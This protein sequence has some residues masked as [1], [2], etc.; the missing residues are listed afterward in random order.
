MEILAAIPQYGFWFLL[1]LTV[2]VFVHEMGHFLVAR[3]CGVRVEV[4]SI[5]FG[6][7]LIGFTDR[8][9]TRW[10]FSMV[11]LGGY[12]RMFGQEGN[13]LEGGAGR[14]MSPEERAV[15]FDA[16][17]VWRRAAIVAAGPIA[18]LI[19][20]VVV[21]TAILAS[22]GKAL[23]SP[24]IG[25]VLP[26]SAAAAAG[27]Q[28][29]DKI[30]S[31]NGSSIESFDEIRNYVVLHLDLPLVLGVQRGANTLS[32]NLTP[33]IVED[34]NIFGSQRV[35][36]IGIAS[37]GDGKIIKLSLPQAAAEAVREV[38]GMSGAIVT[39]IG[40]IVTGK[41]SGEEIQ[42]GLR[43][44]KMT[45][46]AAKAGFLTLVGL[47]A[48]I[49][50]NLGLVNLLPI[51]MLDGGHLAFYAIEAI[52]G[53]PLGARAQEWG[54]RLGVAFVLSLMVFATWNDIKVLLIKA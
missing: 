52:R 9:G 31:L 23:Q 37:I 41:R 28:P 25:K 19:F 14:A 1:L 2:L 21:L 17:S 45:G 38:Y 42:G 30:V 36:R 20:A 22:L 54:L 50:V 10:R 29:G 12:V 39:G 32:I 48:M 47:A 8:L 34:T 5:G 6:P 15:A 24:E 49:S 27:L 40:Q 53:R 51:P 46:E 7:E 16:K 44:A 35:G 26:D 11:P 13:V 4:F 33:R 3:W 43:M 18:N